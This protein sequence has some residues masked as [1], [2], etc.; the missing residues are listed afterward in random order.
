MEDLALH[1]TSDHLDAP[2]RPGPDDL[3]SYF[4]TGGTTGAPKLAAHTHGNE[5]TMAWSLAATSPL[6]EG[7]TLLAGLPLFHVNALLVTGLAPLFRGQRTLWTG[8]LGYRD[9]NLYGVIW[10]L[11]E[12]Y[13]VATMSGV[14]TVYSVLSQIP[15][16]ADL[17]SLRFAAV[18]AS[19][20][21]SAVRHA[22]EQ[23]TGVPLCEGYGLTE[24]TCASARSLP[25]S[26]RAGS[27]GQRLPYQQ[28][29]AV[30]DGRDL[31]AGQN[32]VLMIS[33]PTVFPGYLRPGPGGRPVTEPAGKVIDG[34]LDT[35]DLG[36][37]DTDGYVYLTG[38]AKDLIIRGGHNID[39]SVIEDALLDHPDVTGASA[40]GRPDPHSGEVPIAYVTVRPGAG[41]DETDLCAWAA[42]GVPEPAAAP[43]DVHIVSEL[44]VT[45]VGKPFKPTLREDALRRVLAGDLPEAVLDVTTADGWL[46]VIVQE[47]ADPASV[48]ETLSRYAVTWA[49]RTA[50][51]EG[52]EQ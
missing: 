20:L 27:V 6:D 34:W 38:R 7:A 1:A 28:I 19:P 41:V 31:P 21:P 42:A 18:G 15:V 47:S 16:D 33:G 37:V 52:A 46:T 45:A 30:A 39:P 8:P 36:R 5:V 2:D 25:G 4:H 13:Q 10:K 50:E 32:G 40:V 12:K 24:A 17:S 11:I 49:W 43:K 44:P 35:G 23:H 22:F 51:S 48:E 3:A 26:I 29:K 14:P 9:P